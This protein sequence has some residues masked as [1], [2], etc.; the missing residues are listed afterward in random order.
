METEFGKLIKSRRSYYRIKKESPI[1]DQAIE[2]I[3]KQAIKYS[4]TA[5]NCQLTRAVLLL[6]GAHTKFWSLV[7]EAIREV[8][9]KSL[10]DLLPTQHKIDAF[11]D[12]YGTVLYYIDNAVIRQF[13][14]EYPTYKDNFP[15]WG[16]QASAMLQ[17]S[18]WNMLE[19]AGFGA[20]L[21]HY[22]PIVDEGVRKE[23]NINPDWELIAEMPFGM[24]TEEPGAQQFMPIDQ[25][26]ITINT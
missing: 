17:F 5:F 12:G 20:S 23:W 6:D 22:N 9:R 2:E 16:Q 3:I 14:K 4:P 10:E 13:Q 21:Q 26:F 25:R 1:S 18:V 19:E 24:P 8:T 11:N 7:M 15:I